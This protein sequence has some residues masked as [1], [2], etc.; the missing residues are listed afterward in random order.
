MIL[1]VLPT[2]QLVPDFELSGYRILVFVIVVGIAWAAGRLAGILIGR[3]VSGTGGDAV[4]RQTVVG[5]SLQKS[6]FSA[7][8]LGDGLTRWVIYVTGFLFALETLSIAFVTA[9][10]TSFLAYLPTLVGSLVIFIV[11]VIVSDWVGE[12][13]KKSAS[14]E[15]RDVL[16]LSLIGDG[17]KVILYFVTITIVLGRLGVDVT[18]L[19]IIAQAFAWSVA[20]AVGVAA[21]LVVGWILKDRVKNWLQAWA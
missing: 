21:G 14:A 7:Y 20:I 12:L 10:V 11:G 3:L 18:I 6:G 2:T 5:R 16:Y 4:M 13:I 19:N 1:Q 9:S 17:V 15:V 8:S